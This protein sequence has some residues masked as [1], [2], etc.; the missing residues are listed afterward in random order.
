MPGVDGFRQVRPFLET[1]GG[2]DAD[3]NSAEVAFVHHR[4]GAACLHLPESAV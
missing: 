1:C 2:Y 4:Q 3:N